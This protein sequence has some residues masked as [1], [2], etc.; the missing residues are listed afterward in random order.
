MYLWIHAS[1]NYKMKIIDL[2]NTKRINRLP[3]STT[4]IFS[5]KN[6]S[7]QGFL[8]KKIELRLF[9]EKI[10]EKL[11]PYSLI[12]CLIDTDK[13]SI[14]MI[15]EEG[16]LGINSLERSKELLISNLGISG[17]IKRSVIALES[18]LN[19]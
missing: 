2:P 3:N 10:D 1:S 4:V 6:F 8:I 12:T 17:L 9:I 11:G 15:Y 16:Y 5:E 19:R 7:E 18:A 13:G 14:E